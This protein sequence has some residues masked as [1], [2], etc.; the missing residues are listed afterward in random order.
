MADISVQFDKYGYTVNSQVL[1]ISSVLS[2]IAESQTV[3][4]TTSSDTTISL[5]NVNTAVN[6]T[7]QPQLTYGLTDNTAIVTGTSGT[8]QT[9]QSWYLS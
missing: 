3:G 6:S 2:D 4:V 7:V 8:A 5:N 9:T 1:A